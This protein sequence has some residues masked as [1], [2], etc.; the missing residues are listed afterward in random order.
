LL[1]AASSVAAVNAAWLG[2]RVARTII[3]TVPPML[4]SPTTIGSQKWSASRPVIIT[5][6]NW[7]SCMPVWTTPYARAR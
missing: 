1:A 7:L 4:H 6:A 5:A 2:Q 3:A